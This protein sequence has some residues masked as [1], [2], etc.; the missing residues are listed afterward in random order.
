MNL[1]KLAICCLAFFT[2][3]LLYAQNKKTQ[4]KKKTEKKKTVDKKK[5]SKDTTS[6]KKTEDTKKS[7]KETESKKKPVSNSKGKK[8]KIKLNRLGPTGLLGTVDAKNKTITIGSVD[9]GSPADGKI[10]TNMI[11][12]GVGSKKFQG[13]PRKELADAIDIAESNRGQGRLPLLFGSGNSTKQI[14]IKLKVFGDYSKTAPYNCVKTDAILAAALKAKSSQNSGLYLDVLAKMAI[15]GKAGAQKFANKNWGE[16][17][18]PTIYKTWRWG[19]KTIAMCEYYLLTKDKK[20][21]PRIREHALALAKGQD[22]GGL[23]G[24]A[25]ALPQLNGRLRG[26]AQMNQPSL[27][28]FIGLILATKCGINDSV[29]SQAVNKTYAYYKSYIGNGAFPYGVHDF[30]TRSFNNNGTSATAALAMMAK[31]DLKGAKFFSRLSIAGHTDLQS[32]HACWKFNPLWSPM[33]AAVLGPKAMIEYFKETK[34]LYTMYRSWDGRIASGHTPTLNDG[35]VLYFA[36]G[37]RNL[38]IT[39][40]DHDKSIWFNEKEAKDAVAIPKI[41]YGKL[42]NAELF[43]LSGHDLPQVRRRANWELGLRRKK[44]KSVIS[45]Y[46]K[47]VNGDNR[48]MRESAIDSFGYH[49]NEK[50]RAPMTDTIGKLIGD[51]SLDLSIRVKAAKTVSSHGQAAKKYFHDVVDLINKDKPSDPMGDYDQTLGTALR[52][53]NSNPYKNGLLSD[54]K[55]KDNFYKAC[56]KLAKHKRERGRAP[57]MALLRNVPREDFHRVADIILHV[58]LDKD[59]GYHSYNGSDAVKIAIG[60]L[61]RFRIEEGIPAIVEL[62]KKSQ[63][64]RGMQG[65]IAIIPLYGKYSEPIIERIKKIKNYKALGDKVWDKVMKQINK[66]TSTAKLISFEEAKK[67]R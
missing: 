60:T 35:L 23:W 27:T 7:K 48:L 38:F 22:A 12:V 29:I 61:A 10:Q 34:W 58:A 50:W 65:V 39:G 17:G 24:H 2:L 33:G 31:G 47:Q 16:P 44:D 6:K 13:N 26:Y 3:N 18:D 21:L 1:R 57:G 52:N 28:A 37:K 63:R 14:T 40:R 43:K 49:C 30:N 45:Q 53:I 64:P 42:S 41:G 32:G 59:P 15:H 54:D 25:P 56:M 51:K 20:V 19:Y 62:A 11:L 66:D 8:S 67:M 5:K 4:N 55:K 9:K 36:I 46:Q